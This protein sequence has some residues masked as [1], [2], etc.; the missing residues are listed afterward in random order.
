[1][2]SISRA[3]A[4]LQKGR[5]LYEVAEEDVKIEMK[6]LLEDIIQQW[7]LTSTGKKSACQWE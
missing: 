3:E 6:I 4:N 7:W 1:M 2:G 5:R